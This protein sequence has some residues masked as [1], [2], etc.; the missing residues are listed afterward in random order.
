[1]QRR[2]SECMQSWL[3]NLKPLLRCH[4]FLVFFFASLN[5]RFFSVL[6]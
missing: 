1:M 5:D 3:G 6:R 4:F 2:K